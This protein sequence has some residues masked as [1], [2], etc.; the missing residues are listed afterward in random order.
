MFLRILRERHAVAALSAPWDRRIYDPSRPLLPRAL[1]YGLDKALLFVRGLLLARR[2]HANVVF[3]ETVHHAL[4]GAAIAHMLGIACVW[5]SHGNGKLLYESLGKGPWP[6]RLVARL[7]TFVARE[8]DVL[9]TVS[10]RDAAEYGRMGVPR[11]KIQIVPVCVELPPRVPPRVRGPADSTSSSRHPV[12]LFFGSFRYAPNRE[13]LEFINDRLA[14]FLAARGYSCEIRIAGRDVPAL[15]YHPSVRPLG[16][17]PDVHEALR[18]ATLCVV[19]V[20]RGVGTLTKVID[21]MAVGTP[22][23][24]SGFAARGVPEIRPGTHAYVG[25]TDEEFLERVADALAHPEAAR[26]MALRA[27]ELVEQTYD[28]AKGGERLSVALSTAVS[29]HPEVAA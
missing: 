14:P 4:A 16:F 18:G 21:A 11:T 3:C 29:R 17:V 20:R 13:A 23:V 19:P 15:D 27:R 10:E 7:E 1:L 5:D 12:L 24:L 26:S 8:V 6:T 25:A 9:V 2:S 28:V 22:L